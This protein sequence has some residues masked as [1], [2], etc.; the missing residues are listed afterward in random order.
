MIERAD[1]EFSRPVEAAALPAL[2]RTY[3]I[4]ATEAERR[5]VARRLG[6]Q[7]VVRLAGSFSLT[8]S[9]RRQ[10]AVTGQIEA[11]VVQQCVVTL[12]PLAVAMRQAVERVFAPGG[13]ARH[14]GAEAVVEVDDDPPDEMVDGLIDLGELA[15]EHLALSLDPYPRAPGAV[16]DP[17]TVAIAPRPASARPF[18]VLSKLKSPD[19]TDS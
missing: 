10:V 5:G 9:G 7:D 6:L 1:P 17:A 11:D 2:G 12:Q 18:A 19:N 3:E 13:A 4:A 15:V 8:P 16:F 14:A